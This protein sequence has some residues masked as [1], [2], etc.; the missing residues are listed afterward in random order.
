M[1]PCL[2]RQHNGRAS[3]AANARLLNDNLAGADLGGSVSIKAGDAFRIGAKILLL[4]AI[5]PH[6]LP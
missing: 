4:G 2:R 6:L 1:G 3:R 5:L